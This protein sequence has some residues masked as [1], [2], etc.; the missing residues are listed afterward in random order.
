MLLA[1]SYIIPAL[2]NLPGQGG[3][4]PP[5]GDFIALESALTDIMLLE[6]GSKVELET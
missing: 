6:D 5:L 4:T 1:N 2:N 3:P